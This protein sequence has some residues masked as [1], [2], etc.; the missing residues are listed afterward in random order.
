MSLTRTRKPLMKHLSVTSCLIALFL[1]HASPALCERAYVANLNGDSVSV[2]DLDDNTV[3]NTIPVGDAPRSVAATEDGSRVFVLNGRDETVSVIDPATDTVIDTIDVSYSYDT[4]GDFPVP[5][6]PTEIVASPDGKTVY[7][8]ADTFGAL[9]VDVASGTITDLGER[10]GLAPEELYIDGMFDI[11]PTGDFVYSHQYSDRTAGI[12]RINA[13]TLQ[14]EGEYSLSTIGFAVADDGQDIF[15]RWIGEVDTVQTT[16]FL[17]DPFDLSDSSVYMREIDD[18]DFAEPLVVAP[19]NKTVYYVVDDFHS[20]DD[21]IPFKSATPAVVAIDMSTFQVLGGVSIEDKPVGIDITSDGS[22]LVVPITTRN[23]VTIIDTESFTVV[24]NLPTGP[25][26]RAFKR[27]ILPDSGSSGGGTDIV[28][29]PQS[30][31]VSNGTFGLVV[32]G[33]QNAS[34][35]LE[36]SSDLTTWTPVTTNILSNSTW[37]LSLPTGSNTMQFYR[38]RLSP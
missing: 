4:G 28:F 38:A 16:S 20:F 26:P 32:G 3:V 7:V 24:T 15:S 27:F 37:P 14:E 12:I 25:T 17:V 18:L 5:F 2:I 8:A 21:N 34:V 9:V 36:R 6:E 11:S 33:P 19:D 35:V 29:Q 31:S 23:H 30:L 1:L 10:L 22:R 13:E